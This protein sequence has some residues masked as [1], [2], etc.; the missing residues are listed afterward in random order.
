MLPDTQCPSCKLNISEN[1]VFC[2]HCGKKIKDAPLSTT[3]V[4][5][6]LIYVFSILFPPLGLWPALKYLKQA[7]VKS[8]N[9]GYITL[10][11]TIIS[12]LLTLYASVGLIRTL[13][14]VVTNEMNAYQ[15]LGY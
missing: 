9:I 3:L 12:T 14:T 7:D 11:L 8:K 4:R 10:A 15:D 2:S 13:N 6:I 1:D 5:Q